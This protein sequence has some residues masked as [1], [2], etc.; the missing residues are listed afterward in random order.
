VER[1]RRFFHWPLEFPDVFH[2]EGGRTNG[3]GFDAIVGNPPWEMLRNDTGQAGDRRRLLRFIRDSGLYPA[4][5]DGHLNLYQ[6]FLE[7]ALTLA[8][9][10]GRVG[11]ILPWGV[12]VDDGAAGLRR[13]L[14]ERTSLETIVGLDNRHG[15][16]PVHRGLRFAVAIAAAGGATREIRARFGVTR[17]DE[18]DA[19]PDRDDTPPPDVPADSLRLTPR[20]LNRTGGATW[21]IPFARSPADLA[22]L[23]HLADV[24][25]RLGDRS[26]WSARFGRELNATESRPYRGACGLRVVEGRHIEP[27]R[28]SAVSR[29]RIGRADALR[30]LPDARF[31]APRLGYRD[32]SGVGNTRSLIAAIVP[33]G[34]VTIH[35]VLCLRTAVPLEQQHFLCGLF[36]SYVLNA[37]VR[38]LM[39]GHVTTSLVEDLPVPPWRGD[40][41]DRVIALLAGELSSR[42]D[43]RAARAA[44]EAHVAGLYGLDEGMFAH[45]LE[46]FPLVDRH[47]RDGAAAAFGRLRGR[48]PL[49]DSAGRP[50]QRRDQKRHHGHAGEDEPPLA[51]PRE[52]EG[53]GHE[54][55]HGHQH[56]QHEADGH[57]GRATGHAG[58]SQGEPA[59][60]QHRTEAGAKAQDH[61]APRNR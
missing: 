52:L 20:L 17:A 43:D 36:N 14:L 29:H 19:L 16:F 5:A 15:L 45:V 46:G 2:D 61:V 57:R 56:E 9:P 6:P 12:A 27:F 41:R 42:P 59:R 10:G 37:V 34:A 35:T 44:L 3:Y 51:Q 26:S 30:F 13:R 1:D 22:L 50:E 23:D 7:R 53:D 28:V 40:A 24:A 25:P 8:K 32:V 54:P 33:A 38:L 21:R 39:G 48:P 55:E 49:A 31:D 18:L 60:E 58:E 47:E 11:L 4:C